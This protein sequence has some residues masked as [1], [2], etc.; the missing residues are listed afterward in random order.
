MKQGRLEWSLGP[1]FCLLASVL[2]WVEKGNP[3]LSAP[4]SY[5]RI[6]A[7]LLFPGFVFVDALAHLTDT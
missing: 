7:P 1:N 2:S 3:G 4:D 5:V 6:P